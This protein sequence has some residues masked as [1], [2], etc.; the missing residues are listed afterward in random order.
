MPTAVGTRALSVSGFWLA[1]LERGIPL[2][3]RGRGDLALARIERSW[4]TW[5]G[6]AIE[7]LIRESLLRLLPNDR[8]PETES[9]GGRGNRQN[10]PEIDLIGAAREPVAKTIHFVGSIKWLEDRPFDRHDYDALARSL[11]AVPGA[12]HETA[13]V[14]VSRSGITDNLPL[15]EHR[16]PEDLV[17]TWQG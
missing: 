10:N 16:G 1:F 3:E 12:D 13:L 7:P 9:V 8:W 4:T 15:A 17:R 5:R 6:R 11:P 14:A 2:I